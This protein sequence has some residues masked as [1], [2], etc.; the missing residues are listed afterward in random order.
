MQKGT[1]IWRFGK[2]SAFPYCKN[3]EFMGSYEQERK[4]ERKRTE[5]GQNEGRLLDLPDF[6]GQEHKVIWLQMCVLQEEG[7]HTWRQ[8]LR[9]SGSKFS[10]TGQM[11]SS[12]SFGVRPWG[13]APQNYG[14]GILACQDVQDGTPSRAVGVTLPPHWARRAESKG[15]ILGL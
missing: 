2:S 10:F 4:S 8:N 5:M 3:W 11:A 12:W 15:I 7:K 6:T 14:G 9:S 13:R 1:R